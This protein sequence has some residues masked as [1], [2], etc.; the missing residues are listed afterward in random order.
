MVSAPTALNLGFL[1]RRRYFFIQVAPELSSRG[2]VDSVPEPV[3]FR[4]A[5]S[6]GNRIREPWVYS[7]Q[8]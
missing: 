4:K 5:C 2:R 3:L 8:L 7:K 6:A 1:Q